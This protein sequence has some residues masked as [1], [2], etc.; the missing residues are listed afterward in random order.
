MTMCYQNWP[1]IMRALFAGQHAADRPELCNR[2]FNFKFK[3]PVILLRTE[4]VFGNLMAHIKGIE[5]QKR[6]LVHAQL[7]FSL[8]RRRRLN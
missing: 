8:M 7:I 2:V 6:G 1:E 3:Q 4:K 5:L